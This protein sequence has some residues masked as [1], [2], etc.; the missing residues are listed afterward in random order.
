[1]PT[2]RNYII[3]SIDPLKI[4][5]ASLVK[6]FIFHYLK[7]LKQNANFVSTM[8]FLLNCLG[9]EWSQCFSFSKPITKTTFHVINKLSKV[10]EKP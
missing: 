5:Y 10:E 6:T 4:N 1:M 7:D 3:E 2:L 9:L 8:G